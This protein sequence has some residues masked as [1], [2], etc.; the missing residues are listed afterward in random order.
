MKKE[1]DIKV[2]SDLRIENYTDVIQG[3]S[4]NVS[5]HLLCDVGVDYTDWSCYVVADL[6]F[7]KENVET[8]Q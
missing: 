2:I 7:D 1:T 8:S 4:S 5:F 6:R 3:S